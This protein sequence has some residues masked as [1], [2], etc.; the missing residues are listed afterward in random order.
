[1]GN[2][3]TG[4]TDCSLTLLQLHIVL[5]LP[6]GFALATSGLDQL[7]YDLRKFPANASLSISVRIFAEGRQRVFPPERGTLANDINTM[8]FHPPIRSP[9]DLIV[10]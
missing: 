6:S 10:E 2:G 4:L 9:L 1:M 8:L 5:N 7:D 3:N